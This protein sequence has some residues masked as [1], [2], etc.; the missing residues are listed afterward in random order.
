ML[1]LKFAR[2]IEKHSQRLGEGLAHK[3]RTSERTEGFRII[4]EEELARDIVRL[5]ANLADWIGMRT[6][7]DV[8]KRYR[9]IGRRR[10]EQG[11]PAEELVWALVLSKE[12]LWHFLQR[13]STADGALE[14]FGE[15]DFLLSLEQFFDRATYHAMAGYSGVKKK[16]EA[17]A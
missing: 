2:L 5:Y 15:L 8:E 1:G 7:Q 6:E 16:K 11:I 12:H 3:L 14:L 10:A 13:E 4:P 9:E 17:A